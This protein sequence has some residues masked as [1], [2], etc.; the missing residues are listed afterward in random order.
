MPHLQDRALPISVELPR[1]V[2]SNQ[3]EKL[4][5]AGASSSTPARSPPLHPSLLE[6]S[7]HVDECISHPPEWSGQIFTC[8]R[9]RKSFPLGFQLSTEERG[10]REEAP[11]SQTLCFPPEVFLLCSVRQV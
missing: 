6:M 2:S 10:G 8:W 3:G 4:L 9:R 7:Q 1:N 11:T 5:L